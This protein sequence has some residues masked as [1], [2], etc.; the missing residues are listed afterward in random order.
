M[1][2]L[3][4]I[5]KFLIILGDSVCPT[6]PPTFIYDSIS[7]LSISILSKILARE[8][9]VHERPHLGRQLRQHVRD[10]AKQGG[11][12]HAQAEERPELRQEY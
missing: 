8:L 10:D 2:L 7:T 1:E 4:D 5:L 9:W 6:A 11:F 3:F 12:Y